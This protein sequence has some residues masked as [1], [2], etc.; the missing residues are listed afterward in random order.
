[1]AEMLLEHCYAT[2]DLGNPFSPDDGFRGTPFFCTVY[3]AST[4]VNTT[5][6]RGIP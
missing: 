3:A 5:M 1:M 4:A 6:R 2:Y